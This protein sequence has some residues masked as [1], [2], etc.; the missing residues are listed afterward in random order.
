MGCADRHYERV[1]VLS[2]CFTLEQQA[3]DGQAINCKYKTLFQV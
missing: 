3:S 2:P 1:S